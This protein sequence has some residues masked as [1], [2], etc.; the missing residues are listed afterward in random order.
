YAGTGSIATCYYILQ[1]SER[2]FS[3]LLG[4]EHT[5]RSDDLVRVSMLRDAEEPAYVVYAAPACALFLGRE[6]SRTIGRTLPFCRP[7]RTLSKEEAEFVASQFAGGLGSLRFAGPSGGS[8][9][10]RHSETTTLVI[11]FVAARGA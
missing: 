2:P 5:E 1:P 10:C 4:A 11:F 7:P 8:A 3:P 6:L 9:W